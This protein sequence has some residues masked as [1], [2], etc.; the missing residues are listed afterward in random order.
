MPAAIYDPD[1]VDALW[2]GGVLRH[3]GVAT[4]ELTGVNAK[5]IGAGK[6]GDNVRFS[7]VWSPPHSG[8]DTVVG[9][10]ASPDPMSRAA[11]VALGNYD[12][13]VRFYRDLAGTV[14]VRAPQCHY[15]AMDDT[16]GDFVLVLADLAPAEVG[17][18]IAGCTLDEAA[19]AVRAL[20]GLHAPRWG[21]ATLAHQGAWLGPRLV[22]GGEALAE[23]Y[24]AMAPGFVDRYADRLSA[25]A[26]AT[27]AGFAQVM[28]RW[29]A[30][31][32]G[33]QTLTHN[34]YRLDNLL[35]GTDDTGTYAAVVDWQTVGLGPGVA[36]VAYFV[37]AGLLVDQRR[38]SERELLGEYLNELSA[39]GVTV[40]ADQ[41]WHTYRRT[42]P[43]GMVMAVFASSVVG[44]G[45]RSDAM[46]AAMAER[47]AIQVADLD[48]INLLGSD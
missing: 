28:H 29:V 16:T 37:G 8:P 17:D 15:V 11:G 26:A 7:L 42:C 18:Q 22:G 44:P 47:H 31:V 35:F 43:A 38:A 40:D 12:R 23:A 32:D 30:P 21:D 10:F 4:G 48:V 3:A 2:L 41:A 34:D 20:V 25:D 19:A 24:S 9:K 33:P 13:E 36:D 5:R 39:N 45:D 27:V 6:V 14:A 46:F 1:G